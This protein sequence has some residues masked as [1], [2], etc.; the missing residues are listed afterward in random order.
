MNYTLFDEEGNLPNLPYND[1]SGWSGSDTS[2]DRAT[3]Q[4]ADGTTKNRQV[5]TL[6]LLEKARRSGLTW[7]ELAD[8]LNLHHGSASGVLSV[9]H[10]SGRIKRLT[11]VRNKCKVYVL[12]LFI[13]GRA[14]EPHKQK[15][16]FA[17]PHCGGKI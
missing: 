17:C 16:S 5:K 15:K 2:R 1:T 6:E 10:L 3:K 9:L 14:T 4:D 7:R 12:P 8:A 11:E 13:D